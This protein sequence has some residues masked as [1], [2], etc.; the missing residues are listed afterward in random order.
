MMVM[1]GVCLRPWQGKVRGERGGGRGARG[2]GVHELCRLAWMTLYA[3]HMQGL[4]LMPF[5]ALYCLW[6]QHGS[7]K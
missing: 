5:I 3:R 4:R 1:R 6:Q 2:G 7:R